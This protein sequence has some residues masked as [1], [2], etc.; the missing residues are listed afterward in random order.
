MK[1]T[2]YILSL[3]AAIGMIAGCQKA[4]LVQMLPADQ[5]VAPVLSDLPDTIKIT[6]LNMAVDSVVF[7]WTSA[8]FGVSTQVTYAIEV[9][10]KGG[11]TKAIV[12]SGITDTTAVLYY[13]TINVALFEG[14]ELLDAVA[15][16][17]EF[18]VSAYTLPVFLSMLL[19]LLL[20]GIT[21]R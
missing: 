21:L 20:R 6:P 12:S 3:A 17:V 9:A 19:L 5:A 1:I 10:E 13:E 4:E 18:Y 11:A 16:D 14:L 2:K 8:D 15:T 7:N